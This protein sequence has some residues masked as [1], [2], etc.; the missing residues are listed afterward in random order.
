[1]VCIAW[2]G[3][4]ADW[5]PAENTLTTPWTAQVRAD[6]VLPGY[7]RPQLVRSAWTNLNGL[8]DY[9]IT[10]KDSA[11]LGTFQG[12]ILVPYPVE[13]A[14]SGVKR[15]L[16]PEERLWYRRSFKLPDLKGQRLL[17]HFGAMDWRAEVFVT[18]AQG[19]LPKQ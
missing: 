15:R 3:Y 2:S 1:M 10:P 6:K 5:K 16:T 14:L 11:G 13:S 8:W 18:P 9:A 7:P 17:L 12:S 4:A 19:T